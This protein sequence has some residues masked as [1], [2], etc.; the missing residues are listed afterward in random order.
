MQGET[1]DER[2]QRMLGLGHLD[3]E[4]MNHHLDQLAEEL[5][6]FKNDHAPKTAE[7]WAELLQRDHETYD[8]FLDVALE[9]AKNFTR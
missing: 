1:K 3:A 8:R 4:A 9:T 5:A 7:E 6:S 2:L